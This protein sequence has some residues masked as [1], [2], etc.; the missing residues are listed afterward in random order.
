[1]DLI[2][3]SIQRII[4]GQG[5]EIALTGMITVFLVLIL[6][7]VCITMLPKTLHLLSG[8]FPETP[9]PLPS[10]PDNSNDDEAIAAAVGYILHLERRSK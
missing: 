9:V 3:I 4:D 6:I 1:M 10:T 5:I 2:Q 8:V 7:S